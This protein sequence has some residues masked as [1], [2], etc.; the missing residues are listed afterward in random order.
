[1]SSAV[2]VAVPLF[3]GARHIA[4]CLESLLRQTRP[5]ARVFCIDDASADDS[6][7][8]ASRYVEV[9]HNEQNV[10]LAANWNRCVAEV[11][12][13]LFV[14]AHQDDVYEAR[15][16]ETLSALLEARP[17]AFIAHCRATYIDTNGDA[18]DAP[19]SRYKDSFWPDDEPYER[20]PRREIEMLLRGNYIICPATMYRTEAARELGLFDESLQFVPDWEYWFRGLERGRTIAGT[21]ERWMRYRMHAESATRIHEH[22]MRR[23]EEELAL[24]TTVAKRNGMERLS[25]VSV[26]NNLLAEFTTRLAS[27]DR[28]AAQRILQ[29]ASSRM[30]PSAQSRLMRAALP[31]GRISGKALAAAQSLYVKAKSR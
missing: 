29:F 27:G 13:P 1:M 17:N 26:R 10:G 7:A 6:V 14:I 11:T 18:I 8:I 20:E 28:E 30:P 25:F 12:T 19:A 23:F 24:T 15:H 21:H 2:T 5:A 9:L 22:T 4:A 3:N 16:I 31:F